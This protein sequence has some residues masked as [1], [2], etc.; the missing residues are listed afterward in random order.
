MERQ[1]L[2]KMSGKLHG[3]SGVNSKAI[4]NEVMRIVCHVFDLD[5]KEVESRSRIRKLVLGRQ[6]YC[7]L[8][9]SLDPH[10]TTTSVGYSIGRDHST[11]IHSVRKSND[12]RETDMKYAQLFKA[13]IEELTQSTDE[14]VI[15][16]NFKPEQLERNYNNRQRMME[17]ALRSVEIVRD[18]MVVCDKFVFLDNDQ[19]GL[20]SELNRLRSEAANQGF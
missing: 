19:D 8:C 6:T 10:A 7:S 1:E 2:L 5:R 13:C 15:E 20:H 3:L 14:S 18:F 4:H 17:Q 9:M 16:V 11:V 12:L